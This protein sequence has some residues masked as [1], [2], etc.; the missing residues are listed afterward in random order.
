M[1]KRFPHLPWIKQLKCIRCPYHL[2]YIKCVRDPCIECMQSGR[3][4]HPFGNFKAKSND[5]DL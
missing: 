2:G 5:S 1:K 3:K 4:T